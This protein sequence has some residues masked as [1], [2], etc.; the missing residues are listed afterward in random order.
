M[1][2][3][4]FNDSVLSYIYTWI[5]FKLILLWGNYVFNYLD[6][7]VEEIEC[8]KYELLIGLAYLRWTIHEFGNW[9]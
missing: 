1:C 2:V 9:H 7:F 6:G 8:L 4:L 3:Y 5:L